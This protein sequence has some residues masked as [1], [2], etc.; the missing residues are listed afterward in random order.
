M[1]STK[2]PQ[3]IRFA[4]N[5]SFENETGRFPIAELLSS[6]R[7]DALR[8]HFAFGLDT[9]EGFVYKFY[10]HARAFDFLREHPGDFSHSALGFARF[11][12]ETQYDCL[13][14]L[15]FR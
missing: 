6:A 15:F 4:M 11:D 7:F 12:R 5:I 10:V 2:N 3:L 14:F 1:S 9:G 13:R 8:D